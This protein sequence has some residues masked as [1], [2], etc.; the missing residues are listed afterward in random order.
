[1]EYGGS[2]MTEKEKKFIKEVE[3]LIKENP[4]IEVALSK[5]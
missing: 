2:K 4:D 1:M 3:K 5:L